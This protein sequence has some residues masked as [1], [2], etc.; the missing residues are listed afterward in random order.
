MGDEPL[1]PYLPA[2]ELSRITG[3]DIGQDV[4]TKDLYEQ[5]RDKY[6]V[7]HICI[8]SGFYPD[9]TSRKRSFDE[10]LGGENVVIS[11]VDDLHSKIIDIVRK[12]AG[13]T[14]G[15]QNLQVIGW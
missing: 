8:E 11:S 13:G 4:G 3:D 9:Q 12:H 1:N 10:V 2:K 6:D 5:V 7:V 14:G 15:M